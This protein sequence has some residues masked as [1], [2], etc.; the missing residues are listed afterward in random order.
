M[1]TIEQGDVTGASKKYQGSKVWSLWELEKVCD[2]LYRLNLPLCVHIY[3][4]VNVDNLKVYEP[5]ILDN[6]EEHI[7][8][9]LRIFYEMLKRVLE[10]ICRRDL[11][12]QDMGNMTFGTLVWRDNFKAKLNGTPERQWRKKN[13]SL[14]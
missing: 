2:N 9:I 5:S 11:E 7:Y 10:K 1:A 8:L 14:I 13:I 4:V 6:K 3:S 12:L